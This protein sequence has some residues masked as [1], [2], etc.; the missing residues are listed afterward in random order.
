M[1]NINQLYCQKSE[2]KSNTATNDGKYIMN[3]NFMVL[4]IIQNN[5]IYLYPNQLIINNYNFVLQSYK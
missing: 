2:T 4:C 3:Q 5:D 1:I